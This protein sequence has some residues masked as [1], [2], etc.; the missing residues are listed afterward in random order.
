[1]PFW[2]RWRSKKQKDATAEDASRAAS[3]D[4]ETQSLAAAT[5]PYGGYGSA[6]QKVPEAPVKEVPL[7]LGRLSVTPDQLLRVALQVYV[8]IFLLNIVADATYF[9]TVDAR[10]P[11]GLGYLYPSEWERLQSVSYTRHVLGVGMLQ[12]TAVFIAVTLCVYFQVFAKVDQ[13]MRWSVAAA[14]E[15]WEQGPCERCCG[16]VVGGFLATCYAAIG[17]LLYCLFT[18]LR[19]CLAGLSNCC[20]CASMKWC[21]ANHSVGELL[22]G[23]VYVALFAALFFLVG[24]P[25][26]YWRL[27]IDLDYGFANA[28]TITLASFRRGMLAQFVQLLFWGIPGRFVYLA[29]L[30]FRFG[31]LFMWAGTMI[32]MLITHYNFAAIVP[33]VMGMNN[34]FPYDNFVVGRGFPLM[35]TS[36]KA[37]PWVSMNRIFFNATK[38]SHA[39]ILAT[40]DLSQGPL[41]LALTTN[42]T[43]AIASRPLN[44]YQMP[45]VYSRTVSPNH[46]ISASTDKL[47]D[48]LG[49][50]QW[51]GDSTARMGARS[52]KS[53]RDKVMGFAK[54]RNIKIEEIYMVDGSHKDARANAFVGGVNGSII[55]LYD[56]LFL[57]EREND[58]SSDTTPSALSLLSS[59]D[60]SGLLAFS[61]FV[62]EVDAS[63]ED[64]EAT[65]SSTPTQAM[66]DDEII[67]IL[68][69]EL[70]HPDLGHLHQGMFVQGASSLLTYASLG[71]ACHSPLFAGALFLAE[72]MVHVGA[73]AY[74]HLIGPSLDSFVKLVSDWIIRRNEYQADAYVARMS[75][76]YG[77]A[78]QTA[79]AKL[80]V[81]SN[82]DP[83][84]PMWYEALHADHPTTA[85]RWANI[86]AVKQEMKA[87]KLKNVT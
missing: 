45:T 41:M 33:S 25:F 10:F 83:D 9:A 23:S 19:Y 64:G 70:A 54:E 38:D 30:R 28:L 17:N 75:E 49:D 32:V 4:L 80:S 81:N 46:D 62:Q 69:H 39:A 8:G 48:T 65:W 14:V 2:Q 12:R 1:M 3:R 55:G 22:L 31:W 18:P 7:L 79:L 5:T 27:M 53:L 42:G 16:S 60:A 35:A 67:A 51:S 57:G 20:C 50:Q 77:T 52:G 29:V 34:A 71:W 43:W 40:H 87:L 36:N 61:E 82:Q 24:A 47:L 84:M 63:E 26:T 73:V 66:T 6:P 37:S 21:F 74:G 78:L 59:G 85:N 68:A 15:Q 11:P 72:P 58:G 56:T 13:G 76:K 86:E 44:P